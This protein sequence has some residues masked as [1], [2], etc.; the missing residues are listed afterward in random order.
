MNERG[1]T[2]W[3]GRFEDGPSAELLAFSESLHF[4][5]RLADDDLAGSRALVR[6]LVRAGIVEP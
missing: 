1:T 2:L 6:G 4:D 3:H 5:R